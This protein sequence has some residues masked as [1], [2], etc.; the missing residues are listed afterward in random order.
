MTT[1]VGISFR[2]RNINLQVRVWN[3]MASLL[4]Y[5]PYLAMNSI[6]N[7]DYEY[8]FRKG[9]H[10]I[11]KVGINMT[12]NVGMNMTRNVGLNMTLNYPQ[13]NPK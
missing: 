6:L 9:F 8:G 11:L 13:I 5:V 12:T 4:D 10:L 7:M 3:F 1:N 2:P